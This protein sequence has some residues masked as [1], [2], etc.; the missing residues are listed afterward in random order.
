MGRMVK[1]CQS[2]DL[3][4]GTMKGVSV[5]SREI[6]V[7]RAGG[8]YY[9]AENRCPHMGAKLSEGKLEG[10]VVICPRHGSQFDLKDG[11]VIR[12]TNL[13]SPLAALAKV[14]KHPRP[15]VTY[16]VKL[17]GDAVLAEM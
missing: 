4:E 16:A 14:V 11:H 8:S 15:L 5:E 2:A 7:A 17:D 12:W 1:L 9:A 13:P 3:A 10:S 6:L